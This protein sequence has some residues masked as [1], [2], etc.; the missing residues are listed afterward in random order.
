MNLVAADDLNGLLSFV[1]NIHAVDKCG[2]NAL[3]NAAKKRSEKA[4]KWAVEN[5]VGRAGVDKE[6]RKEG[7]TPLMVACL[8]FQKATLD[9]EKNFDTV[10]CASTLIRAGANPLKQDLS[11]KTCLHHAVSAGLV[12][13]VK[14]LCSISE[15]RDLV[16]LADSS[17]VT[18][19][20]FAKRQWK[21]D[22]NATER[23][24]SVTVLGCGSKSPDL[25]LSGPYG[26]VL[27]C[28]EKVCGEVFIF[29]YFSGVAL[30][31][32]LLLLCRRR[33]TW[34]LRN[35]VHPFPCGTLPVLDAGCAS[36]SP[37]SS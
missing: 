21:D 7:L 37:R 10:D 20:E 1:G 33:R 30:D 2:F 13:I 31:T 19:L 25:M 36:W 28:M 8:R 5:G 26:D 22:S 29:H 24:V 34:C 35:R 23:T 16:N 4:L 17:G 3:M 9:P 12:N 11:G 6:E 14:F 15:A 27:E 18:P 32:C